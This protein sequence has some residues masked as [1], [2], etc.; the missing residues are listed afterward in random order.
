MEN[1]YWFFYVKYLLFLSDFNHL[2]LELDIEIVAHHLCKSE[3][4]TN[5]KR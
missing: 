5:Q 3:Y 4:F 2:A 1:V